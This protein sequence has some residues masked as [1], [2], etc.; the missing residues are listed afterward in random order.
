MNSKNRGAVRPASAGR[1]QAGGGIRQGYGRG[2]SD[3]SGAPFNFLKRMC[4]HRRQPAQLLYG[5]GTAVRQHLVTPRFQHL[6]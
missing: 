4:A 3:P 2:M 1:W 6:S 5:E